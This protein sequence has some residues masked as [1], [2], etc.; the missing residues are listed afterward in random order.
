MSTH[1]SVSVIEE[2]RQMDE[3]REVGVF[4]LFGRRAER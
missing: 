2:C 4:R 1:F 3:A